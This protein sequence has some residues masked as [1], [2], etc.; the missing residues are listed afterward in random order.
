MKIKTI[1]FIFLIVSSPLL[2]IHL[3]DKLNNFVIYKNRT[4]YQY[5]KD[6]TFDD[7]EILIKPC[8]NNKYNVNHFLSTNL[9]INDKDIDRENNKIKNINIDTIFKDKLDNII[10]PCNNDII[11]NDNNNM[12]FEN[13]RIND[14]QNKK[15]NLEIYDKL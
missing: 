9:L 3:L 6:N 13:H 4:Y 8:E 14:Y 7:I 15:I 2:L 5:N 11:N 12:I 10:S 1:L